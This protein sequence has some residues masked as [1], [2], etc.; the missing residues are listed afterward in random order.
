MTSLFVFLL[1]RKPDQNAKAEFHKLMAELLR[2]GERRNDIVHSKYTPWINVEGV[3]GLIRENS[4]LKASKGLRDVE[5]EGL[6][7]AAFE[8]DFER[9]SVSLREL[10]RFRLK[11]IDWLYPLE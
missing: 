5:E 4:K 6:L 10:E 3:A 7:P 11:V 1:R 9:L 2:L 8:T